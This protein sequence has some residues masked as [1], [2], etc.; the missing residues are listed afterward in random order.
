EN[1]PF[2]VPK[3]PHFQGNPPKGNFIVP[4][5]RPVLEVLLPQCQ[6]WRC[7]CMMHQ[8]ESFH[9]HVSQ[10]VVKAHGPDIP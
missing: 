8:L 9:C 1:W 3:D 5:M 10:P 6:W 7:W 4:V 2:A